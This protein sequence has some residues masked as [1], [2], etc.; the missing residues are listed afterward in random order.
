MRVLA[1]SAN[2]EPI[3]TITWQKA[4]SL[5]C[6]DKIIT[7]EEYDQ[8]I[9]SPSNVFK[10]PSVIVM[11]NAKFKKINSIRFSRKNVWLRDEGRCQYCSKSINIKDFT[12]DHVNPRACGGKTSWE[13][14]VV[15]CYSCNQKKGDKALKDCGLK[16]LKTPK[17]PNSL[18]YINEIGGYFSDN[19]LHPTWKFWLSRQI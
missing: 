5:L 12:L 14:V 3:G 8:E 1:L 19:Y 15:S 16:I 17:K 2:Y 9:R 10:I 18:P 13:N 7:L 11:K 4:I 6:T